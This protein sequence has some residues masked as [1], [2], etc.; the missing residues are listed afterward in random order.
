[1]VGIE[2]RGFI[3]AAPLA[4]KLNCSFVLAR[5]TGKL[6]SA[7]VAEEYNLEYGTDSIEMHTDSINTGDRVLIIDDLL[8]TGGTAKAEQSKY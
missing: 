1:M 6:P 8:A 4:I 5:K 3:F 7:T 2:S